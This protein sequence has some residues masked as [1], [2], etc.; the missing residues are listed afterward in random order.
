MIIKQLHLNEIEKNKEPLAVCLGYFDGLHL[1]HQALVKQA[2]QVAL[3]YGYKSGLITFDQ[4]PITVLRPDIEKKVLS[5]NIDRQQRGAEMGLDYWFELEFNQT[6]SQTSPAQ[7]IDQIIVQLGVKHVVVGF[8]YRFGYRG[9]GSPELLKELAAGRYTVDVIESVEYLNEKISSTRIIESLN[10][11]EVEI[12]PHLLGRYYS[13]MGT[14]VGGRQNGSKLGYPTANLQVNSSYVL[15]KVGVYIGQ[16]EVDYQKYP[17]MISVGHNP[18][19]K[20][21]LPLT[22]EAHLIDQKINLYGKKMQL[23][24]MKYQRDQIAFS[25]LELLKQALANDYLE[26]KKYFETDQ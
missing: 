24:F 13:L 23:E 12:M 6:V 8:D 4:D 3:E 19:I 7:F 22:I 16:A 1:G 25:S 26:T 2:Q 10:R 15:P 21:N 18:T 20:D 17:A 9:A 14:V 11:G 5:S